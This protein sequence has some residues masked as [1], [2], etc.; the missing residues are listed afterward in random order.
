MEDLVTRLSKG[1]HSIFFESRTTDSTEEPELSEALANL[2]TSSLDLVLVEGFKHADFNKIELHR[3]ALGKPYIYPNDPN[4]IAIAVDHVIDIATPVNI[5]DLNQPQQIAD[6]IE[7][8][9]LNLK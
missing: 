6:F 8:E 7:K 3:E 2:Q 1:T 9:L 5:L 4:V